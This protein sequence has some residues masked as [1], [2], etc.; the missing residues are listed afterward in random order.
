MAQYKKHRGN[1]RLHWNHIG[2]TAESKCFIL[3]FL[4]ITIEEPLLPRMGGER[5]RPREP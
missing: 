4:D 3:W 1:T 5:V 2:C